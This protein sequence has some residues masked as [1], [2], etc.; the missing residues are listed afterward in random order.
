[1]SQYNKKLRKSWYTKQINYKPE[2][3]RFT[4]FIAESLEII[5]QR[6]AFTIIDIT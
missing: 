5:S 6:Q 3:Y 1:V 2:L 4:V